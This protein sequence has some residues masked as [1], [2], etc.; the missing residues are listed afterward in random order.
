MDILPGL[1][2]L[3]PAPDH[4]LIFLNGHIELVAGEA[5]HR[6]RDPQTFRL[7]VVTVAPL[8]VVGRIAVGAFD[9]AVERT[10]DLVESQEERTGQRRNTRH[11]Q[12]PLEATL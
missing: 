11:S 10:L 12:S 1:V 5:R 2:L 9:D 6:Q 7:A 3:L 4:K 8:D